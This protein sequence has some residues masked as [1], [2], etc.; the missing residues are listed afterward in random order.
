MAA[1]VTRGDVRLYRFTHPD[2]ER[3]V[4]ILTRASILDHLSSVTV[5]PLTS[6]IR[7]AA[8]QVHLTVLDGMKGPCAVNLHNLMTVPKS[9]LGRKVATLSEER[10]SEVCDA[11]RY[12]LGCG[13]S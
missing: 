8:S 12:A 9:R 10:L 4:V 1:E 2:K 6:T 3:P 7:D 13:P 11:L 5:A